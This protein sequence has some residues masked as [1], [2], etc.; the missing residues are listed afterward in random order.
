MAALAGWGRIAIPGPRNGFWIYIIGPHLGA[1][2]GALVY[3]LLVYPS[4]DLAP[5]DEKKEALKKSIARR[6]G[7][8]ESNSVVD[9]DAVA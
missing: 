6:K 4:L 2:F 8:S 9:L 5:V 3:D 1:I 7:K